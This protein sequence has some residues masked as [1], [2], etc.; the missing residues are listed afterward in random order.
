M[1]VRSHHRTVGM[2]RTAA[3]VLVSILAL[4][5]AA[6]STPAEPAEPQP[7]EERPAAANETL[8]PG[9]LRLYEELL[10][11]G[12][13]D[14]ARQAPG[15]A[16]VIDRQ[17]LER[18]GYQDIH[19]VLRQ[20]PG[21]NI[22]EE[23]GFGLRPNIGIR[24]SG[25]ERSS[26]ITLLEDG[27]LIAPA[28]YAAPAAYYAP[29]AGR[30]DGFEIRKGSSSIRQGPHTNGGA[31][32]YLSSTIPADLGG[33][34][35]LVT[36]SDDLRRL[37]ATVGDSGPTVG[38]LVEAYDLEHGGFKELDG[39]GSTGFALED[40]LGKL[41][42]TSRPGRTVGQA[43]E[44]KVGRTRQDGDET[45]VGLTAAD[46]AQRP[47]RRY[48]GS[49]GDHIATDHEQVQLSYELRP[50]DRFRV[51]ATAYRNDFFRN[52]AK[53]DQVAGVGIADILARPQEH[54][55]ELAILRGEVDSS[56]GALAVRN[57]R[58][59]YYSQGVQAVFSLSRDGGF[60]DHDL[61]LGVRLHEDAEDRFQEDDRYQILDG[62]RVFSA[63]GAPGS[64]AN[65]IASAR[66]TA[67]FLEDTMTFGRWRLTPGVRVESIELLREDF[68]AADPQRT[69]SAL[70]RRE[71]SLTE[72]IP[73]LGASYELS[74][75][76]HLLL[77][78]HRGF[79]PPSPGSTEEVAPEESLNYEVGYRYDDGADRA[80]LVFFFNDYDNL[81]GTDTLSG[82]G[83]GS[84]DQFNGGAAE[85]LGVEA[86]LGRRFHLGGLVL[87]VSLTY[88]HT[89]T[90]FSTAFDTAFEDW[91]PAV[92]RGDEIPYVPPHQLHA[93][94][95]LRAAR[96]ALHV[97]AGYSAAMRSRAGTGPIA[98]DERIDGRATLD[99][100]A[101]RQL[102]RGLHLFAQVLNATDEVFVV[103]HRPAGLRP[104]LPR[105]AS[106][107]LRYG[108]GDG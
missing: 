24:G 105:A 60:I 13:A 103:A 51:T 45:Y 95:S 81:L 92:E 70:T 17:A 10:V 42:L 28:P 94:V 56:A 108:I 73:G 106:V 98:A 68:G 39:G 11:V 20:V 59:D 27:V 49:A 54:A 63:A 100:R 22:Q 36:G 34:F 66:A 65:R 3:A 97:D 21:I 85:V 58:R 33:R 5:P 48:A 71:N 35:E 102:T 86:A 87:P 52:W 91:A 46:F 1:L 23:E 29:T 99:L 101:E 61:D 6:G 41:R 2:L 62:R 38:W 16:H 83:T 25:V 30:M 64:N 4:P 104:G 37:R 89:A 7:A 90:R 55:S 26:K 82:G 80:E 8:P 57:N 79:S 15:S 74:P 107:G 67:F 19:R 31:I 50:S 43:L 96:W 69:G 77:G 84:G 32:N 72:A 47:Y 40:Y 12:A 75:A 44:L 88:T 14:A 76:G 93:A 78:V 9:E 53:L 18:Q